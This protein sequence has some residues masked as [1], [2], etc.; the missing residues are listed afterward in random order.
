VIRRALALGVVLVLA[1]PA[2][3]QD[4]ARG[5]TLQR[6][7]ELQPIAQPGD[8]VA[9]EL[10]FNRMAQEKG[11]WTAFAEF[12]TDNA[13]MFV[14]EPVNAQQWLKGRANPVQSVKWQPYQL[15]SSCDGSLAVTKGAWQRPD[16]S[17]GYFTTVW[18]RQE[19]GEYRW[20]MDQ[21][22]VL[23]EPLAEPDMVKADIA[24]CSGPRPDRPPPTGSDGK[25]LKRGKFSVAPMAADGLSG[26]SVDGS[27][28]WQVVVTPGKGREFR[29]FLRSGEAMHEALASVVAEPTG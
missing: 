11:Q 2:H 17:V 23:A 26:R 14:P 21:G 25:P 27:L 18:Q 3:A 28:N 29:V 10:A 1:A 15:W 6:G 13:V 8:V 12:A 7:R 4:G 19:K 5:F 20:V 24:D 22:D 16:G 9:A